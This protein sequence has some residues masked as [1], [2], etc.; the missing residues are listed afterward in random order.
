MLR[1]DLARV[2]ST[3]GVYLK[4]WGIILAM[5]APMAQPFYAVCVLDSYNSIF[6]PFVLRFGNLVVLRLSESE[7]IV[8]Q[9]LRMR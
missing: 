1:Q 5:I 7:I 6:Q 4:T 2:P 9:K 3:L 8:F